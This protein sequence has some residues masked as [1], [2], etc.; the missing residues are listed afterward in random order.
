[1]KKINKLKLDKEEK[2]LIVSIKAGKFTS[3]PKTKQEIRRHAAI[4][5]ATLA[6]TKTVNV[7]ISERDLMRLK[8]RAS[9][10]GL[11]YQT[12]IT[13]VLHKVIAWGS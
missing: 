13:S 3:V 9:R 8:A 1:M 7:R 5:N 10:E 11:S 2:Q 6:K 4:A 12:F